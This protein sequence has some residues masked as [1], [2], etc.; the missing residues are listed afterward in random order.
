MGLY[1]IVFNPF[2]KKFDFVVDVLRIIGSHSP[3]V[4]IDAAAPTVFE[5]LYDQDGMVLFG[6]D[7]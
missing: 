4:G 2:T 7:L 5:F 1:K 6:I 3:L